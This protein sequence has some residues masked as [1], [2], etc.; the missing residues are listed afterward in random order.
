M[1]VKI[2]KLAHKKFFNI[3]AEVEKNEQEFLGVE[4]LSHNS[5]AK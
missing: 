2:E 3:I 5:T 4:I 1:L